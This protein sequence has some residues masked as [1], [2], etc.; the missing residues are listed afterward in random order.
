MQDR[1]VTCYMS[2]RTDAFEGNVDLAMLVAK[3]GAGSPVR[4]SALD[5]AKKSLAPEMDTATKMAWLKDNAEAIREMG[6]DTEKAWRLF[7]QG[8]TDAL[9]LQLEVDAMEEI[10]NQIEEDEDEEDEEDDD[11]DEGDDEDD[12]NDDDDEEDDDDDSE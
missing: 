3:I 5:L 11:G 1:Y 12:D 10:M 8:R 2:G 6:G 4:D 7:C 9:A